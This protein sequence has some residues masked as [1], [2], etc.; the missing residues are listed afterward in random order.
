MRIMLPFRI[1]LEALVVHDG[2]MEGF[3]PFFFNAFYIHSHFSFASLY[4]HLLLIAV[5]KAV[6]CKSLHTE[7]C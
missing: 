7:L 3:H 5:R 4:K 1:L 2:G 6:G